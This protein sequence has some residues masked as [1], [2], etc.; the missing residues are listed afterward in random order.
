MAKQLAPA[1]QGKSW[2]DQAH[3]L[4]LSQY[5]PVILVESNDPRRVVQA[6]QYA[7]KVGFNG[8]RTKNNAYAYSEWGGLIKLDLEPDGTVTSTVI[9]DQKADPFAG[10][11]GG[12]GDLR[13]IDAQLRDGEGGGTVVV[14]DVINVPKELVAAINAWSADGALLNRGSTIMAFLPDG[15]LPDHVRLKCNIVRPP[16]STVEERG[17]ILDVLVN[18]AVKMKALAKPL[19]KDQRQS[20]VNSTA[21]LDLNQ[22][23]GKLAETINAGKP[24]DLLAIKEA[25][26]AL[27]S[28]MGLRVVEGWPHGFESVGGYSALKAYVMAEV[29]TPLRVRDRAEKYGI[30]AAKGMILFGPPGT[31]KTHFAKALS[32]EVGI[33]MVMLDAADVFSKYVGESEQRL[34]AILDRV[35]AMAPAILMIDEIDQLSTSRGAGGEMDGGT[36]R[37]VLKMTLTWLSDQQDVFV[38]GTTNMVDSIDSAFTRSGRF[39][40]IAPMDFPDRDA[41]A[42]IFRVQCEVVRKMPTKDLDYNALADRTNMASGSDIE[43]IVVKAAKLAMLTDTPVTMDEFNRVLEGYTIPVEMRKQQRMAMLRSVQGVLRDRRWAELMSK[44]V[45]ET[46][47]AA[48][49]RVVV[50]PTRDV[51]KEAG[52]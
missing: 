21:G 48:R 49:A 2:L 17:G 11:T 37:R 50:G 41:R 9:T 3:Q 14:H 25:K 34:R 46:A 31:G 19:T 43:E 40:L 1:P 38:V 16:I 45:D 27:F 22:L 42:A 20:I 23:E 15:V 6:Q 29:V 10:F 4:R 13:K 44:D 30:K 28:T 7:V 5:S 18:A 47:T 35:Q 33:P 36:S 39:D 26:A 52:A 32:N 12:T 24:F 8:S 51:A